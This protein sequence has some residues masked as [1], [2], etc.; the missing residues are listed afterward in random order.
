MKSALDGPDPAP[1]GGPKRSRPFD[2]WWDLANARRFDLIKKEHEGG[3]LT[4]SQK[5]ELD[6]LQKVC[7]LVLSHLPFCCSGHEGAPYPKRFC[8]CPCHLVGHRHKRDAKG[9]CAACLKKLEEQ[10]EFF[11]RQERADK[12]LAFV[13]K[14]GGL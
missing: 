9:R 7:D 3:G 8:A 2:R 1:Y 14:N 4:L 12:L 5:R 11:R 10:R 6:M 13:E